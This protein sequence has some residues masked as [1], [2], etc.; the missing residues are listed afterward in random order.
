VTRRPWPANLGLLVPAAFAAVVGAPVAVVAI[1]AG[2]ATLA[3]LVRVLD[4]VLFDRARDPAEGRRSAFAA[5]AARRVPPRPRPPADLRRMETLV[6]ARVVTATGVH[7]WLRPLLV[8]LVTFRLGRREGHDLD[9]PDARD[10]IGEPLWSL[11]RP[12]RPEPEVR[13][14][15]G[16]SVAELSSAVD[17]LEAL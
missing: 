8:D 4:A 16:I 15:P 5:A 11:V 14:G 12:D 10:R 13:D 17:G 2:I 6:A 1:F 7:H 9:A 3:V